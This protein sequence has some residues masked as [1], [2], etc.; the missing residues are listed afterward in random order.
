[1]RNNQ[2][3]SQRE[4]FSNEL[5]R[6]NREKEELQQKLSQEIKTRKE[7]ESSHG[8]MVMELQQVLNK[9]REKSDSLNHKVRKRHFLLRV[10]S[11]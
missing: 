9:E 8:E 6:L 3:E 10:C 2:L 4:T 5:E 7:E 11:V 1:M